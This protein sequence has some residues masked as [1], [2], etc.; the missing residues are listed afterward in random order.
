MIPLLKLFAISVK[1]FTKPAIGV[2]KKRIGK[3]AALK[4]IFTKFGYKLH[5]FDIYIKMKFN[6]FDQEYHQEFISEE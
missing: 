4:R 2:L 6:N 3:R 1:L 5:N